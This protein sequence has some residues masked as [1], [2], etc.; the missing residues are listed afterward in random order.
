MPD[1]LI[2]PVESRKQ[3]AQPQRM[4][5]KDNELVVNLDNTAMERQNHNQMFK[6]R[7]NTR[8]TSM[9]A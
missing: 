3:S 9:V 7:T 6:T 8:N 2:K 1:F 5:S 4:L